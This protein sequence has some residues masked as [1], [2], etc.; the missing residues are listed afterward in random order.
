M[1]IK[2]V[3]ADPTGN[4]TA[5]VEPPIAPARQPDIAALIMA[6][7][8][9]VEQ[10]GFLSST[11]G[12]HIA[13][14]M[15]GGEF[16]GNAA[17]SAAA[18]YASRRKSCL[19]EERVSVR[20]SGASRPVAVS[21]FPKANGYAGCV[22]MPLPSEI[23]SVS[24][25]LGGTAMRLPIVHFPGISHVIVPVP[26]GRDAAEAAVRSWCRQLQC[27]ALGLMMLDENT[28]AL[29]PLVY[30]PGSDTMFWEHSC[31]SGTAAAGAWLSELKGTDISISLLEPGGRLTV[32]ARRLNGRLYSLHLGGNVR[33]TGEYI[34]ETANY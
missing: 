14:R 8:P 33:I 25:P 5:L 20:V 2:Y 26:A 17:M 23:T 9:E 29:T 7:H 11:P 15:A 21:V 19:G 22:E 12:C 24:L 10:V 13:L 6:E 31:A 27:S 30:V 32:E 18:L 4:I 28:R 3:T 34:L 1:K 16:C